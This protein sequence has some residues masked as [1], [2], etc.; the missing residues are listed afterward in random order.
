[1]LIEDRA[2]L[3][4]VEIKSGQTVTPD[5]IRAAQRAGRIPGVEG[6]MPWLVFGGDERYERSG[7]WVVGWRALPGALAGNSPVV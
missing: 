2:T 3:Q 6:R 5:Y 7:V 1:M 4:P